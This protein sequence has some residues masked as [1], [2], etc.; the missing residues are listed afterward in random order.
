MSVS[1]L[2]VVVAAALAL[3]AVVVVVL[4]L[5]L[6][7][8]STP[9]PS[10]AAQ[11]ARRHAAAVHAVALGCLVAAMLLGPAVAAHLAAGPALGR[12]LAL[13]PALAGLAFAAVHAVGEATW[14]RPSGM[15]R[16]APLTRRTPGDVAPGWLRRVLWGWA[17]L[18]VVTLVACGLAADGGRAIS[19]GFPGGS[20]SSGPFPGWYFGV[21]VLVAVVVVVVA[22]EGVLRLVADRAVVSD[23]DPRWDVALRRLSAH[24][25]LRGA[26]LV[27]AWTTAGVLVV[28]GAAVR[29]VGTDFA[30]DGATSAVAPYVPVGIALLAL[31]VVVGLA[32]LVV[33]LVPGTPVGEQAAAGEPDRVPA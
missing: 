27:L 18:A 9:S 23:A 24:R 3:I 1:L 10:R 8:G 28:A 13:V 7:Q 12:Y 11:A 31:G 17:A 15:V 6:V 25:V 21:P 22:A 32:G 33:A 30:P 29:N 16:R 2:V 4:V 20:A 19:R 5:V 14:P 26:Q